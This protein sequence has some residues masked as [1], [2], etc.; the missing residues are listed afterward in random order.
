MHREVLE[1]AEG[2]AES[3]CLNFDRVSPD[4]DIQEIAL[5]SRATSLHIHQG[6]RTYRFNTYVL[7]SWKENISY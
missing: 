5:S 4:L 2:S 6:F 1:S 7:R 3:S